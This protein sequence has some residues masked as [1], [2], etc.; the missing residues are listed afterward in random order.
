MMPSP[1]FYPPRVPAIIRLHDTEASWRTR[2]V[3]EAMSQGHFLRLTCVCGKITDYP[4]T[5]LLQ[6][7]GVSRHSFL[8]NIRFKCKKCGS[9]KYHEKS[10]EHGPSHLVDPAIAKPR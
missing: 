4:L 1:F 9:K 3:S 7:P 2:T 8:D 10:P 6:R 5:L